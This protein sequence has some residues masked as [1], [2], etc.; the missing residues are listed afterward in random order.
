MLTKKGIYHPKCVVHGLYLH[1][2]KGGHGL[3]GVEDIDNCKY[4]ALAAYAH[5]STD[6]LTQIVQETRTPMQKFLLKLASYPNFTTPELT[7]NNHHQCLKAKP[8]HGK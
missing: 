7:D 4:A 8:L 2:S 1:Q 5:N 3:T 6:M